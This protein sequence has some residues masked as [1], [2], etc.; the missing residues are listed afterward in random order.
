[1]PGFIL[2]PSYWRVARN[3][4]RSTHLWCCCPWTLWSTCIPHHILWRS[5]CHV[6][7]PLFERSHCILS[8]PFLSDPRRTQSKNK[9]RQESKF[10]ILSCIKSPPTT[11]TT[12]GWWLESKQFTCA[13]PRGPYQPPSW[14]LQCRTH[15]WWEAGNALWHEQIVA[16]LVPQITY[17]SRFISTRPYA[18]A[19][20]KYLSIAKGTMDRIGLL[21]GHQTGWPRIL[22]GTAYM[23]TDRPWNCWSLQDHA[24][25]I[26]L[27]CNTIPSTT[28][29]IQ[30]L[31]P[32]PEVAR[33]EWRP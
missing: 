6:Q 5:T 16:N 11:R 29:T 10:D 24:V 23:G 31:Q 9:A 25:M 8:L 33:S 22:S 4:T 13:H 26:R 18:P 27:L 3:C 7:S 1:M 15:S 32:L 28:I 19:I 21:Q 12:E 20:W 17:T 14:N 2:G 30:R